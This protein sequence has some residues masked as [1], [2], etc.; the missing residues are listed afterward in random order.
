MC[1]FFQYNCITEYSKPFHAFD[2]A[3]L[4]S[5]TFSEFLI[6]PIGMKLSN[7]NFYPN[8]L[9]TF[10]AVYN[11]WFV[12]EAFDLDMFEGKYLINSFFVL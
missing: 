3:Y 1:T 5:E 2:D 6:G 10:A 7:G 4:S 8:S 12:S 9:V 11:V